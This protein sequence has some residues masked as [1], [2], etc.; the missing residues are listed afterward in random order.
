MKKSKPF[1]LLFAFLLDLLL[2]DPPNQFHPVAW[3]GSFLSWM[4]S[5]Y[6]KLD[7]SP[8][9]QLLAGLFSTTAGA[10]LVG[11]IGV[12]LEK[13]VKKLAGF[14]AGFL[15]AAVLKSTFT[16]TGL[17]NAAAEVQNSLEKK[18]IDQA[19]KHLSHH[20]VS[21]DTSTLAEF[22]V[23]AAAIESVSENLSDSLIAPL[24][25]YTIGGLPLALIYRF[26]NTADAMFGYKDQTH[27]WFGKFPARL[28]DLLNI[29][30]ARISG[31]LIT[32]ASHRLGR[33]K[34]AFITM[35]RDSC[36][37]ESPNAG[38]PMSA[39]AGGL[40]VRLEKKEHYVLGPE[41][42]DPNPH[43]LRQSRMIF[44]GAAFLG[45]GLMVLLSSR[46]RS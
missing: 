40:G 22:E 25:F 31:H 14:P 39:M 37:T 8:Q 15:Q 23:S 24:F 13:N 9:N 20:L 19:R 45:L 28:D 12:W 5:R 38:W 6:H 2:G 27:Y 16:Y 30:P 21:R 41:H 46:K 35:H 4:K 26:V 7:Q 43:K 18:K 29:L 32:L 3:M 17:D 10:V 33:T 36:Q 42:P 34:Q 44:Q 11:G 1:I